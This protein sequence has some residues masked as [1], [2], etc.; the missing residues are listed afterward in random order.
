MSALTPPNGKYRNSWKIF[1]RQ[2]VQSEQYK[3]NWDKIEWGN[4]KLG[5]SK[6]ELTSPS[7][8]RIRVKTSDQ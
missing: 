6:E 2:A 4:Q 5:L 7:H 1:G 8:Y 3:S